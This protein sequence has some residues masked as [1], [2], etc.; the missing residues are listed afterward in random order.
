MLRELGVTLRQRYQNL[1]NGRWFATDKYDPDSVYSRSTDVQRTL[2]SSAAF[3]WGLYPNASGYYPS[4]DTVDLG[5]D[6]LLVVNSNPSFQIPY[7]LYLPTVYE[8]QVREY[9]L[10]R[11][12]TATLAQ[13]GVELSLVDLCS[14]SVATCALE[15]QD[16][17]ASFEAIGTLPQYP[18]ASANFAVLNDVRRFFNSLLYP[19]NASRPTDAAR[20]S[21]G[22]SLASLMVQQIDNYPVG[23]WVLMEYSAHD[24]TVMPFCTALGVN[25][26]L[27]PLFGQAYL[28]ELLS[29][30]SDGRWTARVLQAAPTQ[31]PGPHRYTL[32][33]LPIRSYL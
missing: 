8:G 24:T 18:T 14:S 3:L 6:S 19:Y 2:Q 7:E 15:L 32:A 33:P 17:A 31:T 25:D 30:R 13:I 20:G 1:T 5:L 28:V 29:R 27:L 9:V 11:M 23:P 12:S 22:Y 26:A 21:L 16:V 10:S 4:I